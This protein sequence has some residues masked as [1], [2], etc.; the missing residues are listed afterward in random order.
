MGRSVIR[1]MLAFLCS[2]L[3]S[4][5]ARAQDREELELDHALSFDFTTPHTDWA[6][7]Y[8]RG[9]TRVL[10]F[11]NGRGTAPRHCVELMQRF[12]LKAEAVFWVRII[13][14]T[15]EQ[16]HGGRL[17]EERMLK[18]LEQEWDCFVAFDMGLERM[19]A[20]AQYRL[21]KAVAEG[22]GLVLVGAEDD[23][24]LKSEN[25]IVSPPPFLGRDKGIEAY[26]VLAGRGVVVPRQA[27][28]AFEEG[29]EVTYDYRAERLGRAILWAAGKE[30]AVAL[31][32]SVE[33]DSVEFGRGA[34]LTVSLTG[35][36]A[37]EGRLDLRVRAPARPERELGEYAIAS[38][39]KV[40]VDLP[41]L[42]AGEHHVDAW[43][44]SSEATITW[45]TLPFSVVA[46]RRVGV[47]DLDSSWG[48]IGDRIEGSVRL[49]G[50][51]LPEER[52]EVRLL[53]R[54][55]RELM[56]DVI[57]PEDG[58]F[59]F[60]VQAWLPMRVAVE[61]RLLSRG[62]EV[63]RASQYYNVTKRHRGRFNFVM[64]D[65]P[66]GTL[67]PYAEASLA[68][69]GVTVQLGGH[70]NQICAAHD[71]AWVPYTTRIQ[72]KLDSSGLMQP[73]CWNDAVTA[74]EGV[75]T[76]AQA[77]ADSRQ[78]G[79][80]VWSLGDEVDTQG[81]C[82]SPHCAR[83]YR[84]Y[85]EEQYGSL[86]A[87]NA[88]WGT[89]FAAWEDVALS[90]P[91]DN[92]ELGAR[93]RGNYP[94]WFDR[95]AFRSWNFVQLCDQYRQAYEAIDPQAKVGFE[96]AGRF[97]RG[98]DIDLIVRHNTFWA[99][100][101]GTVDEVIRSIAPRE[102]P[103]A[104][105]MG[106]TKDATSLLAKYWRMVTRGADAVWWWRWDALGRFH[107]WLAPDLSPFPA[108][109][110]ILADTW[111]MREGLGDLLL[112]YHMEDDG[113]AI[114]YSYPSS[115]ATSLDGGDTYGGYEEAHLAAHR[116]V[117]G[118]GLQFRYVTDRMLRLGEFE[119]ER[120]RVLLLPRVEALSATSAEVIRRFVH[121][122]GLVVADVRTGI[123][124]HHLKPRDRGIL[125][126]LFGIERTGRDEAVAAVDPAFGQ[127]ELK[128]DPAVIARTGTAAT[129]V[130]GH[131]VLIDRRMG[132]GRV[133]LL[134]FDFS[135]YPNLSL[136]ETQE[137]HAQRLATWLSEC[138]VTPRIRVLDREG[139]RQRN[140]EI[141][142]WTHGDITI[143]SLFRVEG[144]AS[145]QVTVE[146]PQAVQVYDIRHR[147]ALGR[148]RHFE[149][150]ILPGRAAFFATMPE[151][152]DLGIALAKSSVPRGEVAR[153]AIRVK[154]ASGL[155]AL[156]LRTRVGDEPLEWLSQNVITGSEPAEIVLPVAHNDPKGFYQVEAIDILTGQTAV[157]ELVVH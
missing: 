58:R 74:A 83:A 104:N 128:L 114:L 15:E 72:A 81:S 157:T 106:Y 21:L 32:L 142:R 24:V 130:A 103:R 129:T 149:T 154:G 93:R 36:L 52:V 89:D 144:E 98:D 20:E 88:S 146:L 12:D 86:D 102:F 155:H 132:Q 111:F 54:R 151:A 94:R 139:E 82:L 124:D 53:D 63:D 9:A 56:V 73:F 44:R 101:P 113:I 64:W 115:L 122:G 47:V 60:P 71:V 78:H 109:E 136:P 30:P 10:F 156:R 134:N 118:L 40:V 79:V 87:L 37:G 61:A 97:D 85:I 69:H 80:F 100:Y 46:P 147:R 28:V 137:T 140:L 45:A 127:G 117:R 18:L 131:P 70:P 41:S 145:S 108:V 3:L 22:A 62:Q 57:A 65:V 38:G 39:E 67:A 23:R 2:T 43:I 14:S 143:F 126:D 90:D 116:A 19:G 148:V 5:A 49:T 1:A 123:F 133:I 138:G 66:R 59:D 107:G 91:A 68:Q 50:A 33:P 77:H 8:A 35:R 16:W 125:D 27:E 121:R 48:E 96:G 112:Q 13:D 4:L 26:T 55:R 34:R 11:T 135:S 110:E 99:P 29:W 105:W 76:T 152:G 92:E 51:P 95:Q 42:P 120:Y 25:R 31:D 75:H 6:T 119:A 17:G 141:T 84:R 7:P 150:E 153:A